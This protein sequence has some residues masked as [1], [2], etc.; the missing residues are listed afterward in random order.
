MANE[1][2]SELK[3]GASNF[4]LVGKMVITPNTFKMESK[5]AAASG[6]TSNLFSDMWSRQRR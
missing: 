4:K 6:M 2:M 5:S 3:K 1:V